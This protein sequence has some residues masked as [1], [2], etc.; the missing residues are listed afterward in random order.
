MSR[1]ISFST[2]KEYFSLSKYQFLSQSFLSKLRS[3]TGHIE[4]KIQSHIHV[5]ELIT[6]F[7]L[8]KYNS[9]NSKS[10]E[11]ALLHVLIS[12]RKYPRRTCSP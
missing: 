10:Y 4:I 9:E 5:Y 7:P 12:I 11:A 6:I 3:Y 2:D 1:V 8:D